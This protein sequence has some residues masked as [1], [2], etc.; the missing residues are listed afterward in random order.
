MTELGIAVNRTWT[1]RQTNQ[2][3]EDTTFVE[4]TLWGRQAEVAAQYLSKGRSVLIEGRLQMDSWEDKET[5]KTRTKLKVV[6]EQMTMVGGRGESGSSDSQYSSS[7]SYSSPPV[8][9]TS[10]SESNVPDD[11][12]VPF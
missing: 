11:S 12:D 9:D 4:V 10:S 7:S 1:D 3:R 5:G 6:G 2:R 8:E